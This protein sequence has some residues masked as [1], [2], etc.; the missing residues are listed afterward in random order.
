M[1]YLFQHTT[2]KCIQ[3]AHLT[4]SKKQDR[5]NVLC[6]CTPCLESVAY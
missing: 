4:Y 1:A 6:C 5:K 3:P 2:Y